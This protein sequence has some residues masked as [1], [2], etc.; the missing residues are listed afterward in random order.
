MLFMMEECKHKRKHYIPDNII[1]ILVASDNSIFM[2]VLNFFNN[3][4]SDYIVHSTMKE[5]LIIED[6]SS[7]LNIITIFLTKYNLEY[8]LYRNIAE[9][10]E[11]AIKYK[12]LNTI[13]KIIYLI[14][15]NNQLYKLK[16]CYSYIN[17]INIFKYIA[18]KCNIDDIIMKDINTIFSTILNKEIMI[19]IIKNYRLRN[20][21]NVW[22][23]FK[24][25]Y[26]IGMNY[27]KIEK[28]NI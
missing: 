10:L 27:K 6:N 4:I 14:S 2:E 22:G 21:D 24:Y 18:N 8:I 9:L 15:D 20:D 11:I 13:K 19:Y 1:K 23:D 28:Y 7:K 25:C 5:L 26:N 17:D 12:R 3:Y 16:S